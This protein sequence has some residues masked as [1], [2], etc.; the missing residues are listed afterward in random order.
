MDLLVL[1]CTICLSSAADVELR[2]DE[3]ALLARVGEGA[4]FEL[5]G[6][7]CTTSGV[8]CDAAHVIGLK[9]I[10]LRKMGASPFLDEAICG[11]Q[12][13]KK[14]AITRS[15]L[16]GSIPACLGTSLGQLQE[17]NLFKNNIVGSIPRELCLLANLKH[18]QFN[19]NSISGAFP[20][21]VSQLSKLRYINFGGNKLVGTLPEDIDG[22]Q[23]LATFRGGNNGL[24][25]RIPAAFGLM[26]SLQFLVLADNVHING[27]IPGTFGQL[28]N[29]SQLEL[30]NLANTKVSGALPESLIRIPYL[31]ELRIERTHLTDMPT[32]MNCEEALSGTLRPPYCF[33][34]AGTY[35]IM[36][37]TGSVTCVP[38]E[39]SSYS[40]HLHT[41]SCTPCPAGTATNERRSRN[42]T[43]CLCTRGWE[44][45]RDTGVCEQCE[46]GYEG[47]T[48]EQCTMCK[49]G[50][51]APR[52]GSARCIACSPGSYQASRGKSN[53]E[54]CPVGEFQPLEGSSSCQAC[55][56]SF[57]T[58]S[59]GTAFDSACVCP[60]GQHFDARTAVCEV[61]PAH[62]FCPGGHKHNS[63]EEDT[64][65]FVEE[66]YMT[67]LTDPLSIYSCVGGA[68]RCRGMRPV[69]TPGSGSMC[70][71]GFALLP[72]CAVCENGYFLSQDACKHCSDK[73]WDLYLLRPV[74]AFVFELM[75]VS[76]MYLRWNRP[77]PSGL[78]TLGLGVS[79][80][81]YLIVIG[82]LPLK[83]PS[84]LASIFS[85]LEAVNLEIAY[86]FLRLECITGN[87]YVWRLVKFTCSPLLLLVHL[88]TLY[89]IARCRGR[90]LRV[91][92]MI[93]VIGLVFNGLFIVITRITLMLFLLKPMPNGKDMVKE[94][95]ELEYGDKKWHL[96]WPVGIVA[97][98]IYN[99]TFLAF[100][101][102]AVLLAPRL[103]AATPA[104]MERYRFV[105]GPLRPDRWWW[106]LVKLAF[107]CAL[108]ITQVISRNVQLQLYLS[109]LLF[110]IVCAAEFQLRPFKYR[111]NNFVD[112]F[113]KGGLITFLV[114]ATAFVD[115]GILSAQDVDAN[116]HLYAIIMMTVLLVPMI[117][118]GI[119]VLRWVV[120]QYCRPAFNSAGLSANIVFGFRDVMAKQLL[121]SDQEVIARIARIG[122]ADLQNFIE[123]RNTILTTLLGEQPGPSLRYQRLL[124][125]V[126]FK[127]W[128]K[129]AMATE[130]LC[131]VRNGRLRASLERNVEGRALLRRL[132][133][134]LKVSETWNRSNPFNCAS[135]Q[136][137]TSSV[138]VE[139]LRDQTS[140]SEDELRVVYTLLDVDGDGGVSADE[141]HLTMQTMSRTLGGP[142]QTSDQQAPSPLPNPVGASTVIDISLVLDRNMSK[143]TACESHPLARTPPAGQVSL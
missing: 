106:A 132:A 78:V 12:K 68:K 41:E 98:C 34:P 117:V 60:K 136:G 112:L 81:Q 97:F 32:I 130:V 90:R 2:S 126:D 84:T 56:R 82:S 135:S 36:G 129:A 65:P 67:L 14:V 22:L 35:W 37:S 142:L 140:L 119:E 79:F 74:I 5:N 137:V 9:F 52:R 96:V 28:G 57:T 102:R 49:A 73:W 86:P 27:S 30:L 122:D 43:S 11:L 75:V 48:P 111:T 23:N 44:R 120:T 121:M 138:F 127:V 63:T 108:N 53:C 77:S 113:L 143:S 31:Q 58:D 66:G 116:H 76:Y 45:T 64:T 95:P 109:I 104:F 38:C 62:V 133:S 87:S 124:P 128:D 3:V 103:A 21:C 80:Y 72:Q 55:V 83:W 26:A 123:A 51:F 134:E 61:C 85:G 20:N 94:I 8:T 24:S 59:F 125:G 101:T 33:C 105:F 7:P 42:A 19:K 118:I 139:T 114:F 13:L 141:F 70:P 91:D 40:E 17:L 25:G 10:N 4:G 6:K 18:L 69:R 115:V 99:V 15:N 110:I 100:V 46:A 50:E 16:G 88:A 54:M 71:E 1:I 107:G 93:N 92:H 131:A 47:H 89:V 29:L 39:R